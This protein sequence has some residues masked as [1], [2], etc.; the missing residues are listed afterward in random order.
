[1]KIPIYMDCHATTPVDGRVLDAMLPFLREDFG[2]SASKS[3]VFGWRAEE[4]VE[5]ARAEIGKLIGASAREMIFTSGATEGDNLALKGTAH[6]YKDKG[7]HLITCQT[8]HKAVLDSMHRLEREGF[9][10]SYLP[11]GRDGRL[12]PDDLRKAIRPDTI[13]VSI[14]HG[15][16]EVGVLHPIEE[17]GKITR[18][19]GIIF[20][21]DAVQTIGKVPFDV[22]AMNADLISISAHKMY[23]PKGVGALYVRRKPRARLIAEIDGGG[24]ERGLRSGTLNVPGIVGLGKACELAGAEMREESARVLALREKLRRGIE[25]NVDLVTVNGSLE[26]RL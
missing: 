21:C 6:F 15:N 2:N 17:I 26:H 25:S 3:H 23:G 8:E 16:N 4:A 19:K 20:H 13:L 7:R 12:D 11:V 9:E 1:M 24:H 18:E 22:E 5:S 10:V 14:M